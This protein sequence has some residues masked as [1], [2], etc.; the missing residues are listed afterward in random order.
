MSLRTKTKR[1]V[2]LVVV[3]YGVLSKASFFLFYVPPRGKDRNLE[4]ENYQ[5][6]R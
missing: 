3:T 5:L 1:R 4:V 6:G 2:V